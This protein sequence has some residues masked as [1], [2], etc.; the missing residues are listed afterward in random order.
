MEPTK[1]NPETPQPIN[2]VVPAPQDVP[3]VAEPPVVPAGPGSAA[4]AA[5]PAVASK[6]ADKV[7]SPPKP[8]K[9]AGP[10]KP[11]AALTFAAVFFLAL[12]SMAYYAYTKSN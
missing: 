8:A 4:A 9:V 10:K 3:V 12:A 7:V 6:P 2:D 1:T 5:T 11:V